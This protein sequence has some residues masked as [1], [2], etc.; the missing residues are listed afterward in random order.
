MF[1]VDRVV[2]LH[3]GRIW[4]KKTHLADMPD[5]ERTLIGSLGIEF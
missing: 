4:R 1:P 5:P 3:D 2:A